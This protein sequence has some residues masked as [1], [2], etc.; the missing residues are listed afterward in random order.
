MLQLQLVFGLCGMPT[1]ETW[2]GFFNLKGA[3]D[4]ELDKQYIRP[5]RERFKKW[6]VTL[7]LL[8]VFDQSVDGGAVAASRRMPSICWS[9]CCSSILRSVSR[10]PRQ[11]TTTTFGACRPASRKSTY[12]SRSTTLL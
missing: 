11:W 8:L 1:E 6:V 9:N 5:L 7:V 4:I 12:P 2:P 10:R 3:K